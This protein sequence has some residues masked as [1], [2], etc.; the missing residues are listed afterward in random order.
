[1]TDQNEL[2]GGEAVMMVAS[3][4]EKVAD[5][6]GLVFAETNAKQAALE[7]VAALEA[8][9]AELK[10]R[11]WPASTDVGRFGD[12]SQFA[13]LR[14]GLDGD[15]DVYVSVYDDKGGASIE[16]C[17]PGSGGG[18]SPRT[19]EALIGVMVAMEQD[20]TAD[21]LRDWWKARG[22]DP[23]PVERV[24][25]EAVRK[26]FDEIEREICEGK[27]T[28]ASVFTQMRT[29]AFYTT[30]QPE[31]TAAQLDAQD[32]AEVAVIEAI[33]RIKA[34]ARSMPASFAGGYESTTSILD[35]FVSE[36]RNGEWA[37]LGGDTV[38]NQQFTT[39]AQDVAGPTMLE[40]LEKIDAV[41]MGDEESAHHVHGAAYW[42]NAVVACLDAVRKAHQSGGAK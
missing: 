27:H 20:N 18:A 40:L 39:A 37:Q 21:P 32:L 14:V 10:E 35:M 34:A 9:L 17:V 33:A 22:A 26:R 6:E 28:A 36:I 15:N 19:R 3:L 8:E 1:M 11:Q 7:H 41:R 24:G 31:P 2:S 13:H 16:F 29:A 5:L 4:R 25:Q 42:N 12:M 23:A 38:V 30:P